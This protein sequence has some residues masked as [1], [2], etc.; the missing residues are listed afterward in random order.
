MMNMLQSR[1]RFLLLF[2]L[3]FAILGILSPTAPAQGK[4][5]IMVSSVR[6]I[7]IEK[8]DNNLDQYLASSITSKFKN[9]SLEV[10]LNQ[11]DA[12]A[13]LRGVNIGA[14]STSQATVQL[15]DRSGTQIIWS[16]TAGDRNMATLGISHGGL[17]KIADK[18]IGDLHKA[19]QR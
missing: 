12:D 1:R 11:N 5:Q 13:I 9:G 10:V 16:A 3:L 18:L 17:Q 4:T 15:V 19:M 2:A 14:Q 7:Y 8:M 6:K